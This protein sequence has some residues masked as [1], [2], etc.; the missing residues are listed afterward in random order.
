M[1]KLVQL[2]RSSALT[3]RKARPAEKAATLK[4]HHDTLA[5]WVFAFCTLLMLASV[6]HMWTHWFEIMASLGFYRAAGMLAAITGAALVVSWWVN[7][8]ND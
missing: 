3:L 2:Q 7:T 1:I 6:V 8:G 5:S 4:T